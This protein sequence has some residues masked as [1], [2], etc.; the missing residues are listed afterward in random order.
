MVSRKLFAVILG[1][2]LTGA[3][4]GGDAQ[5]CHRGRYYHEGYDYRPSYLS[6]HPYVRDGLMGGGL[7][8]LVGGVISHDGERMDGALKGALLGGGAGLGYRFL[9]NR[10]LASNRWNRWDHP[11]WNEGYHHYHHHRD[12]DGD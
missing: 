11:Y 12:W 7:G 9:K 8:A 5:A 3:L 2:V 1:L 6:S 10:S 4:F